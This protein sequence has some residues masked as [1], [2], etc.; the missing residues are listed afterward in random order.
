MPKELP[1]RKISLNAA[2]YYGLDGP[3]KETLWGEHKGFFS[4][5]QPVQTSPWVHPAF[6]N[7][8]WRSSPVSGGCGVTLTAHP[9]WVPR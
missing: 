8:Y 7:G 9:H 2:N 6:S 1:T 5:P 4:T 3:R